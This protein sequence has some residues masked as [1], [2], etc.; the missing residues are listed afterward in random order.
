M[1]YFTNEQ[2]SDVDFGKIPRHVAIIPDGNRRWAAK[3]NQGIS[4]GH[5]TGCDILMDIVEAAIE[6]GVHYLTL[7]TF[8][9]ENWK[10]SPE[11]VEALMSLLEIY[12]TE[13]R[14]RMVTKGVKLET[15]GDLNPLP[16]GVQEAVAI[17]KEKTKGCHKIQLTLALNYGGREDICRAV[18]KIIANNIA[19]EEIN[20]EMVSRYLDTTAIPDPELLIRTS[21]E[22]RL[23]NYMLWQL[24]Y[25][26]LFLSET[27]WPD[28]KPLDFLKAVRD[29]QIRERRHGS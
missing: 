1:P 9:T 24:S 14:P 12:L 29:Y 11:E 5:K 20:E 10:R 17:S 16:K 4:Y 27:L 15:I 26:E 25:T 7:Y 21:G 19:K 18:K 2:L 28:F 8:S 22:R 3:Q 13:Q 23:S 6:L